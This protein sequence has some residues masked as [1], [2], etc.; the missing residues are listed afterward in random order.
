MKK[1]IISAIALF[2]LVSITNCAIA[3]SDDLKKELSAKT[4]KDIRKEA[5]KL[6][7]DGW[8]TMPGKLPLEKQLEQSQIAQLRRTDDGESYFI[9][10]SASV[11]GGNYTIGKQM[12]DNNAK[13]EICRSLSDMVA[14]KM[15]QELSN[16]DLG[17]NQAEALY[18]VASAAK[19]VSSMQIR[20]TEYL[21]EIFRDLGKG[22][23]EVRVV[24]A[25]QREKAISQAKDEI[26]RSL[27][28][29]SSQYL[30]DLDKVLPY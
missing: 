1:T 3:G 16:M 26:K 13:L 11:V 2:M 19:S 30:Q 20:G 18:E 7:S 25:V 15:T 8:Q 17:D 6:E 12:A 14:T 29:K 22:K 28:E 10:G 23:T 9:V 24:M 4:S 5:K 27:K 21:L